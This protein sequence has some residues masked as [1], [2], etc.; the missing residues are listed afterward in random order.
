MIIIAKRSNQYLVTLVKSNDPNPPGYMVDLDRDIVSPMPVQQALKWGYWTEVNDVPAN[1]QQ[2]IALSISKANLTT[3][4][5][6]IT[7][8]I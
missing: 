3:A 5:K 7:D 8:I 6:G 2:K 4:V 1:V